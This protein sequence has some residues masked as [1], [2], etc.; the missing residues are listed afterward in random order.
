MNEEKLWLFIQGRL[1]E[2][3][4]QAILD[5]IHASEDNKRMYISLKN[6]WTLS[7]IAREDQ[8][9]VSDFLDN[10]IESITKKDL[11]RKHSEFLKYAATIILSLSLTSFTSYIYF[12]HRI[13]RS[14]NTSQTIIAP[15]GQRSDIEMSD[16]TT[17]SLNSG[18]TLEFPVSWNPRKRNV[19]LVGEALFQ[20]NSDDKRPFIVT[21]NNIEIIA[22]GTCFNIN[23]KPKLKTVD[24][25]LIS[26]SLDIVSK[27]GRP[28]TQLHPNQNAHL[29]LTNDS[30]TLRNV[31]SSFYTSWKE[32]QIT[33]A[34]RRLE[35]IAVD[36]ERWYN[37]EI[38]FSKDSSR[39]IRYS[40]TIL[41][42]KPIDQLL[43]ILRL[44]SNFSYDIQ[45]RSDKSSLI[46]I[47]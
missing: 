16:G 4:E 22:T 42:N 43:E 26:G 17:V 27:D 33:F 34:N 44:T 10:N 21:I 14:Y 23:Y 47:K 39:E 25:T 35:D 15:P 31:D 30:L 24:V 40:G 3:D 38:V 28:L 5:W 29:N 36:L 7:G 45:I 11:R 13:E 19:N 18:T 12:K 41:K 20:V 46:T 2:K 6:L 1:T 8:F 32:G 37:V 9:E